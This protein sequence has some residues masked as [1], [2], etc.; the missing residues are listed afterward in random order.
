MIKDFVTQTKQNLKMLMLTTPGE[1]VMV[2]DYGVGLKQFFFSNFN[3][4]SYAAIQD[5]I[6]TQVGKWM[7]GI[8]ILNIEFPYADPDHNYLGVVLT[9]SIPGVGITERLALDI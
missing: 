7:P 1:R 2:P 4:T 3:Q 8:Q 9:Y 5:R 6:R